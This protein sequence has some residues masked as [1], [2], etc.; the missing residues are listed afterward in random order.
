MTAA[1]RAAECTDVSELPV[2]VRTCPGRLRVAE[3]L[4]YPEKA[5]AL[6]VAQPIRVR[7]VLRDGLPDDLTLR[8]AQSRGCSFD[9]GD[10]RFV[11][12]ERDANHNKA[13]LP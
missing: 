3:A 1:A 10:G 4:Q 2:D 8:A 9:L 5:R 11:E 13:I 6:R 12:G 7:R